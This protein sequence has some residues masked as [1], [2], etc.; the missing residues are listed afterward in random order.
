[1]V[2]LRFSNRAC[3]RT[4]ACAFGV[5]FMLVA[6]V[7]Q[8]APVP[9]P[10]STAASAAE[11]Q[12]WERMQAQ[13]DTELQALADQRLQVA[14]ELKAGN[15]LL[16]ESQRKS[17]DWWF[18]ALAI[19]TT[20][21]AAVGA[22]F[23]FLLTRKDKDA[24]QAE[25]RHAQED[26]EGV[27]RELESARELVASIRGHEK[28][29]SALVSSYQSG[30][31]LSQDEQEAVANE[32]KQLMRNPRASD[33]E[34]LLA[35]AVQASEVGKATAT[36]AFAA[37]ELWQALTLLDPNKAL[38][39]FNAG[40]WAQELFE[41]ATD[42]ERAW[43]L[44][45]LQ[46]HYAAALRVQPKS[47]VAAYNWGFALACEARRL[48]EE[49]RVEKLRL[50]RLAGE[51]YHLALAI[52]PNRHKAAINWGAALVH[53]FHFA[54]DAAERQGLL[55]RA[56]ALLQSQSSVNPTGASMVAYNLACCLAL[57]GDVKGAMEQLERCAAAGLLPAQWQTDKDFASLRQTPEYQEWARKQ[58][59]AAD[60]VPLSQTEPSSP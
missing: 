13:V 35:R 17:I 45:R 56:T 21:V 18:G 25:L 31:P 5:A 60:P 44:K 52:N 24:L 23:P 22:L 11:T 42:A 3:G 28:Q 39:H 34:R 47:D 57:A 14:H 49:A 50:W 1:M 53:E 40:Y 15:Q 2:A 6:W 30:Q 4:L 41:Q 19:L 12:H 16:L 58:G 7:A 43:W 38:A 9:K 8:A 51:K 26:R 36:Q 32:A 37:Y 54:T 48:P 27:R 20:L 46:E 29:I 33:Y 59:A 55:T 10:T